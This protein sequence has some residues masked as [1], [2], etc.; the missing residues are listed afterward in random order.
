[1]LAEQIFLQEV[2]YNK[3]QPYLNFVDVMNNNKGIVSNV[4]EE[5]CVFDKLDSKYGFHS[6]V[7]FMSLRK[8]IPYKVSK[9]QAIKIQEALEQY[10]NAVESLGSSVTRLESLLK[11]IK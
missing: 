11:Q 5:H 10:S 8:G 7:C 1:M 9:H 2:K 3:K 6:D 4:Q